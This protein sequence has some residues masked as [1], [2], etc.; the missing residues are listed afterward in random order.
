MKSQHHNINDYNKA[1]NNH[2]PKENFITTA[3]C[4]L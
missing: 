1:D 3:R 2:Y 4:P